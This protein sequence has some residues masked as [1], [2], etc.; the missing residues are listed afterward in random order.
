MIYP[1]RVGRG[2]AQVALAALLDQQGKAREAAGK[3][4]RRAHEADDDQRVEHR[5]RDDQQHALPK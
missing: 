5:A 2:E 3:Q 1:P 4:A